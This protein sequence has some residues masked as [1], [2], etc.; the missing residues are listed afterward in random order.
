MSKCRLWPIFRNFFGVR[1]PSKLVFNSTES[2]FIKI[3]GVGWPKLDIKNNIEGGT[4]WAAK[5]VL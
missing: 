1:S 2:A 3:L 5:R 4:L